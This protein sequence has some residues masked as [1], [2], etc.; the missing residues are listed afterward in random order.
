MVPNAA[1][2]STAVSMVLF[3]WELERITPEFELLAID[4]GGIVECQKRNA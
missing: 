3:N 4:L 2:T 1:S